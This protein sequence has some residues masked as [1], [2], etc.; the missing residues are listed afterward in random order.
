MN[1]SDFIYKFGK[2][3]DFSNLSVLPDMPPS[4]Y[5][6]ISVANYDTNLTLRDLNRSV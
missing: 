4:K 2:F 1:S 6:E 5:L 3:I